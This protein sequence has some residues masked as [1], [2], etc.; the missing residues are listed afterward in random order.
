MANN[1]VKT[2]ITDTNGKTTEMESDLLYGCVANRTESQDGKKGISCTSFLVGGGEIPVIQ[3]A[4]PMGTSVTLVAEQIAGGNTELEIAVLNI[5]L[6]R[7]GERLS[8]LYPK[9]GGNA[10]A[11]YQH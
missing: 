9:E 6:N 7:I 3:M 10:D 11:G 1:K 8:A 4:E 5:I 2:A